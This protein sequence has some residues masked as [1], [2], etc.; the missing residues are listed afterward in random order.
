MWDTVVP[1][2]FMF[3]SLFACN[4]RN[5][6][7]DFRGWGTSVQEENSVLK[8][9]NIWGTLCLNIGHGIVRSQKLTLN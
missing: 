2:A 6:S 8:Y 9:G 1:P 5:S 3:S 4:I 7:E